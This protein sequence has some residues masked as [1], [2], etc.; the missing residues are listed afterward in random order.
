[1]DGGRR[2][3]ERRPHT[4]QKEKKKN[5]VHIYFCSLSLSLSLSL[6]ALYRVRPWCTVCC[7]HRSPGCVLSLHHPSTLSFSVLYFPLAYLASSNDRPSGGAFEKREEE[8]IESTTVCVPLRFPPS[9]LPFFSL[10][11][12]YEFWGAPVTTTPAERERRPADHSSSSSSKPLAQWP[13]FF[14]PKPAIWNG[15]T[16]AALTNSNSH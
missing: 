11:L 16:A 3:R 2:R 8:K 5:L 12:L 4:D 13:Q 14:K 15:V 1:M 7:W 10:F 6:F 9:F